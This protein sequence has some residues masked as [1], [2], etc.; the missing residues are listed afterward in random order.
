MALFVQCSN[1]THPLRALAPATSALARVGGFHAFTHVRSFPG[2]GVRRVLVGGRGVS[3]SRP[4]MGWVWASPAGCSPGGRETCRLAVTAVTAV[5]AGAE[6][7]HGA[8][9]RAV[10]GTPERGRRRVP[11]RRSRANE[12]ATRQA[13]RV[14]GGAC[15]FR[16]PRRHQPPGRA[17]FTRVG[18]AGQKERCNDGPTMH[19][20]YCSRWNAGAFY[21]GELFVKLFRLF[22]LF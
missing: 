17:P 10:V 18:R 11:H 21:T 12:A 20:E 8:A 3:T 6:R 9:W 4:W 13:W 15:R 16:Q 1:C 7:R 14:V 19:L 2:L 5:T 22:L